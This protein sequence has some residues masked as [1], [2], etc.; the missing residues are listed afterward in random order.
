MTNL[1]PTPT[2]FQ[3]LIARLS[4]FTLLATFSSTGFAEKK[5]DLSRL[6]VVG[7]SLSAGFQN[8]SLLNIQQPHGYAS[9]VASQARTMLPLPLIAAPGIPNVLTLVS[10]GPPPIIVPALGTST[11]RDNMFLQPMDLAVP[12][13]N[14]QD[15]LTTRPT[16]AFTTYTDVVLGLPG[17][18][19]GVSRSQVEWAESLSPT[20]LLVWLGNNDALAVIFTADPAILTPVALF[21]TAYEE[22]ANRLAATGATLVFANIPDVTVIPYLTS[23]E[24]V[25]AQTGLPLSVVGPILGISPGDFVTPDAFPLILARLADPSLGSLPSHV[26]LDASEVSIVRTRIDAYNEII[27]TQARAKGAA[28]VDIHQLLTQIQDKGF[29]TGGQRMT[30]DFLGGIFSLDGIHPTNT[31]YGIV[32]NAFIKE[33]NQTFAAG[34]PPLSVEQIKKTDP[35]VLADA[36]RSTSPHG[37]IS[38]DAVRSLR[39]VVLH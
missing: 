2:R 10:P 17:L 39:S 29:V 38:R 34:I 18:L 20:T 3:P 30:A 23:A 5:P 22:V 19:S 25:A 15:A 31:G 16:P 32:A 4:L 6:V 1:I 21:K 33:L 14:V 35:L 11:G 37:H 9:L 28:L 13:A 27:E 12:G 36:S 7:D 26:V 8:G 24:K